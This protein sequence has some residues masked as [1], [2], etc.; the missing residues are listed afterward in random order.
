[1]GY[2][3]EPHALGP[4]LT[5]IDTFWDWYKGQK[6]Q[7]GGREVRGRVGRPALAV[8][9]RQGRAAASLAKVKAGEL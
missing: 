2:E 4:I 6:P 3:L 5:Q 1:M 9:V 8:S 7:A